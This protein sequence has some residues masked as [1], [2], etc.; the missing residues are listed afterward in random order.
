MRRLRK[1]ARD[2]T[3]NQL[4]K[5]KTKKLKRLNTC[6]RAPSSICYLKHAILINPPTPRNITAVLLCSP[7][8]D[9]Y[10]NTISYYAKQPDNQ[11]ANSP[12]HSISIHSIDPL[13]FM[14]I[15]HCVY[16]FEC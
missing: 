10:I 11:P 2:S 5:N 4:F 3:T 12:T 7:C 6:C 1:L 8:T 15:P 16:V 14:A 9:G 13:V